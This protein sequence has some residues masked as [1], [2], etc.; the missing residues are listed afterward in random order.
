MADEPPT[1]SP[2]P[3]SADVTVTV[4][5]PSGAALTFAAEGVAFDKLG[6]MLAE[7]ADLLAVAGRLAD[8]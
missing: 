5:M 8:E 3:V 4:T 1:D 6:P 7:L 2:R